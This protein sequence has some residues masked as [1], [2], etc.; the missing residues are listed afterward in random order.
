MIRKAMLHTMKSY[1][2]K[3]LSLYFFV[4]NTSER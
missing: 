3:L 1:I 2:F 4:V